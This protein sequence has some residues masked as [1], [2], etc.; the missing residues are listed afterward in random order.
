MK[1][2]MRTLFVSVNALNILDKIVTWIALGNPGNFEVNPLVGYVIGKL[3]ST[4]TMI[5]YSLA[6]F[7]IFYAAYKFITIKRLSFGKHDM[8]P[9]TFFTMLNVILCLVVINNIFVTFRR[10]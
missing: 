4:V 1:F 5:L 9:E 7:F 8:S 6:G 3:G 2:S 10:Q